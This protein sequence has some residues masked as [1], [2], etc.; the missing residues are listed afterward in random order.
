[1]VHEHFWELCSEIKVKTTNQ[2]VIWVGFPDTF[3]DSGNTPVL[4]KNLNNQAR[5]NN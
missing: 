2:A 1:M 5:P 4:G 3:A